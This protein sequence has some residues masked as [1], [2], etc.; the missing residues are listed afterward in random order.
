MR[1]Y[2]KKNELYGLLPMPA[3]SCR[4]YFK[5][6]LLFDKSDDL[7]I[8]LQNVYAGIELAYVHHA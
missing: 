6:D 7:F 5:S 3:Q 4:G 1:E 8:C 2:G